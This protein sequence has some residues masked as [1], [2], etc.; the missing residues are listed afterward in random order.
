MIV[1]TT[2]QPAASGVASR[3]G[4][5]ARDARMP[6]AGVIENMS[7]LVCGSCGAAEEMFGSGGGAVLSGQLGVPL[8]GQVPLDVSLRKAG[9]AGMPVVLSAPGAASAVE[10]AGIASS[11]PV[12]RRSLVGRQLPLAVV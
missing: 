11:L 8:L 10:L 3:V 1:V 12:V 7:S 9:D 5:M 2:P 6:I 4:R